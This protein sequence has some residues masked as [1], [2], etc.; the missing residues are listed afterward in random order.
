MW[1]MKCYVIPVIT[2]ATGIVIKSLKHLETIPGHHSV[3]SPKK[4]PY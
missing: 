3:D 1:N 4:L 2:G